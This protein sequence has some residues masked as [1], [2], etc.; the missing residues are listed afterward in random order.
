[1][2]TWYLS[3]KNG[4]DSKALKSKNSLFQIF[5]RSFSNTLA[6]IGRLGE[7]KSSVGTCDSPDNDACVVLKEPSTMAP[8]IPGV[9]TDVPGTGTQLAGGGAWKLAALQTKLWIQRCCLLEWCWSRQETKADGLLRLPPVLPIDP[10]F[11]E[12]GRWIV[13]QLE[14]RLMG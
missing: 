10:I 14:L 4:L 12:R 13:A 3:S 6:S 7:E 2:V 8:A 5:A 1:M 11:L 9:S